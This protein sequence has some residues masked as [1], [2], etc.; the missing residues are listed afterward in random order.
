MEPKLLKSCNQV[1][2]ELVMKRFLA[3]SAITVMM[4]VLGMALLHKA[5][6]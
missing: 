6:R 1:I 4:G 3:A 2:K 5:R